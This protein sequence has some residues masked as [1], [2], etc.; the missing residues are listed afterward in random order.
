MG[1]PIRVRLFFICFVLIAGIIV[2]VDLSSGGQLRNR[3]LIGAAICLLAAILMTW[4]FS[5]ALSWRVQRLQLF[6]DNVLNAGSDDL[7]LPEEG[8]ETT[9]LNQS[10]RRM[11]QRIHELV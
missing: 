2:L 5:A 7:A 6:A 9:A 10:L 3:V 4:I 1:T 11:A 8:S